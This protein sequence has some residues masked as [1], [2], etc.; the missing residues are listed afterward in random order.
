MATTRKPQ[1]L[2]PTAALMGLGLTLLAASSVHGATAGR[3]A[4]LG[5]VVAVGAQASAALA[6]VGVHLEPGALTGDKPSDQ[7]VFRLSLAEGGVKMRLLVARLP[8]GNHGER[9]GAK[10][11]G[12]TRGDALPSLLV[13]ADPRQPD[14]RFGPAID[15]L[16]R[17]MRTLD[18][19]QF[20]LPAR[21]LG[22]A[23]SGRRDP[24]GAPNPGL[25]PTVWLLLLLSLLAL[26]LALIDG[27]RRAG[28]GVTAGW[29][30]ALW[31]APIGALLIRAL[32][33]H[34]L[35]MVYFG[36]LHVDQAVDLT[37]LPR[38]G[39]ATAALYHALFGVLPVH[40]A[41]VQ[42]LHV[43]LGS[44]TVL[45]L[46]ALASLWWPDPERRGRVAAVVAW[47][48]ALLPMSV[49]DHGSE[50]ILV[51][52]MLWWLCGALMTDRWF[53]LGRWWHLTAAVVLLALCGLSRPD[54]MAVALPGAL[55]P[56]LLR[57]GLAVGRRRWIGAVA[58][59]GLTATLWVPGARFLLDRTAED[60]AMGNLPHLGGD[61]FLALPRRL[62]HDWVIGQAHY[63]PRAWTLLALVGALAWPL[64]PVRRWLV[65]EGEQA[66]GAVRGVAVLVGLAL[67]WAI[68]M[69]LDFNETSMLRL[70]APSALLMT[71]AAATTA[72]LLLPRGQPG[73]SATRVWR[74]LLLA[75]IAASAIPT[76]QPVFARQNSV[77]DDELLGRV[78][79]HSHDGQPAIYVTRAY[80]DPPDQGIHLL[81][82]RYLLAA[83]DRWMGV[84]HFEQQRGQLRGKRVFWWAGVRCFAHRRDGNG[85][86]A[87]WQHPACATFCE[88]H[89]CRPV[90]TDEVA[91]VG[92]RGFNWYPKPAEVGAFAVGLYE[93][94]PRDGGGG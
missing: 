69:L 30:R 56:A 67:L 35:V 9:E 62:W 34:R 78:A 84:H 57:H 21:V 4:E 20:A 70:H 36:Y 1:H 44:L 49:L 59:V 15:M 23:H 76:V 41:T 90:W 85:V 50:S 12:A 47:A 51:P 3:G 11:G 33:P 25:L 93:V 77:V 66:R 22:D 17:R 88:R 6:A 32:A 46:A 53:E 29:R 37:V 38:Y 42:W 60:A 31:L 10:Q 52:A 81:Q 48:T 91:N 28:A 39:A 74:W 27:T 43:V 54:C 5:A 13:L 92:E 18:R 7:V 14:A 65:G 83:G 94:S 24:G 72:A 71:A 45:P 19:G 16:M 86:Q 26:P 68:P 63:F 58:L 61:F 2:R 82:P 8:A 89:R 40:H 79:A 64:A 55:L 80:D 73:T 87:S 75:A